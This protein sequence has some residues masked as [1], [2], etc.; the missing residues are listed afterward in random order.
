MQ[1]A[2]TGKFARKI[3]KIMALSCVYTILVQ[4]AHAADSPDAVHSDEVAVSGGRE[5]HMGLAPFACVYVA[6]VES[7]QTVVRQPSNTTPLTSL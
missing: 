2:L 1:G 5:A 3:V 4:V 7:H 6:C